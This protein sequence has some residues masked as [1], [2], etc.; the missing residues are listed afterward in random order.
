MG[1]KRARIELFKLVFEAD[2]NAVKPN[3]I[4]G[5]FIKREEY[6]KNEVNFIEEYANDISGKLDL[7]DEVIER[8]MKGWK[9]ERIGAVERTL[10]RIATYE[11]LEKELDY[12][13]VVNEAVETAKIYGE[14][15]SYE[16]INGVLANIIKEL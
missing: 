11:I 6:E 5:K 14:E 13:I 10:I 12:K 9:L 15:K 1:R 7:I 4:L 8:N 3:E 2:Q 16:F